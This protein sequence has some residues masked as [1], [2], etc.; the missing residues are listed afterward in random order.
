MAICTEATLTNPN[1]PPKIHVLSDG[2]LDK[3]QIFP[4][5]NRPSSAGKRILTIVVPRTLKHFVLLHSILGH[6]IGHAMWRCSK[7]QQDLKNAISKHLFQSGTFASAATAASC[8]Y[9][10]SAPPLVQSALASLSPHGINQNTFFQWAS[11]DAWTD[12]ILCDFIG[13]LTFGP[14]FVAAEANLLYSIDPSGTGIGNLHPLVAWRINYLLSAARVRGYDTNSFSSPD[15]STPV[16]AFWAILQG[17]GQTDPWFN[18]FD[19]VQIKGAADDIATLLGTLP[20]ALYSPPTESDLKHLIGQLQESI[21]P[22]GFEVESQGAMKCRRIDFRHILY[23]G[24]IASAAMANLSFEQVNRLCEHA[25][26]QQ[27]AIDIADSI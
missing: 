7:H 25:L 14:S 16:K 2:G 5:S 21:P 20:P 9:S 22:T 19:D 6:E 4:E 8:L 13:I 3:Y 23:A 12:E 11:F 18:V 10:P 26:M 1:S 24:W 17:K 27:R 15:V